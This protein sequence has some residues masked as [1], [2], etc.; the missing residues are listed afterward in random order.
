MKAAFSQPAS[1]PDQTVRLTKNTKHQGDNNK[2]L[3]PGVEREYNAEAK[4]MLAK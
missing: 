4:T 2:T 3:R 1:S